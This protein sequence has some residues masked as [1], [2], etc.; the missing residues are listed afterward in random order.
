MFE[1]PKTDPKEGKPGNSE[2]SVEEIIEGVEEKEGLEEFARAEAQ[3]QKGKT[4]ETPEAEEL[5][6]LTE[7]EI[8][9]ATESL[10]GNGEENKAEEN[11]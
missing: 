9:K 2:K 8:E 4:N 10:G 1:K 3:H 11:K 5:K 7:E 6:N